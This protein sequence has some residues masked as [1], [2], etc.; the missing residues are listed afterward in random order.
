MAS[1]PFL[2]SSPRGH[3]W[4]RQFSTN[5]RTWLATGVW[6]G[7]ALLVA[8]YIDAPP[9]FAIFAMAIFLAGVFA[10]A[11]RKGRRFNIAN[12]AA[13][14]LLQSGDLVGAAD[15]YAMLRRAHSREP[16]FES[17]ATFNLAWIE[18]RLGALPHAIELLEDVE[19]GR[20]DK[21]V[22]GIYTNSSA[23]LA[24]ARALAGDVD[25]ARA[26]LAE[27]ERR[28]APD[29]PNTKGTTGFR[30]ASACIVALRS[31]DA[32]GAVRLFEQSW[33][34]IDTN[35]TGDM[36]R[37]IRV[38]R[39]F[40]LERSGASRSDVE[41]QLAFTRDGEPGENAYLASAWPE[42]RAFLE[43]EGLVNAER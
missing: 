23:Q 43:R 27:A 1:T 15:R 2:P 6:M 19:R 18:L 34:E 36:L 28:A 14:S 5:G 25:L 11:L 35:V 42:L 38:L 13:L 40:A 20:A 22:Q 9:S 8:N 12:N 41:A 31:G 21:E 37:S 32:A 10:L 4:R 16:V 17:L 39:A 30:L 7:A 3:G 29:N 33:R 26:W 24:F